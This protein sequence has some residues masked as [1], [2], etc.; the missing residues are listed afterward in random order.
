VSVPQP[1][2]VAAAHGTRDGRDVP[3]VEALLARVRALRP[4]LDVR[5]AYLQFTAPLAAGALAAAGPAVA[6]PLLLSP[7]YHVRVDLPEA[8]AGLPVAVAPVLGPSP[9]LTS[10]L[11]DRLSEAGWKPGTPVVLAAAGSSD[12]AAVLAVR[13]AAADLADTAGVPVVAG[14]ASAVSPSIA[15]AVSSLRSRG[16]RRVA[17][18]SYLIAAGHFHDLAVASGADVVAGPL[19]DHPALARLVLA[20]Y[21]DAAAGMS[22]WP[23]VV[24]AE[25]Q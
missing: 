24:P 13:A 3:V 14:F 6:V 5:P 25:T 8:A 17:V 10:A 2:L 22:G 11:V 1:V 15:G 9:L 21:D 20:R 23:V 16:T 19:G 7:G 18:S 12:P 4:G